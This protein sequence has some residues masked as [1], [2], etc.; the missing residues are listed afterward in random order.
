VSGKS[1]LR[2][3]LDVSHGGNLS[4]DRPDGIGVTFS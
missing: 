1:G 4:S 2:L 3:I